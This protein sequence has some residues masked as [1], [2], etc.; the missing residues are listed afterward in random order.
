MTKAI[1]FDADGVTIAP[2][3]YFSQRLQ[4][5]V[6]IPLEKVLPFFKNELRLCKTGKADLKVEI[7]KYLP[8]WGWNDTLDNLLDT[9]FSGEH[10]TDAEILKIVDELRSKGV[11][12]H[13][14]SDNE[15]YRVAYVTNEM[16]LGKR[17]DGVFFSCNLGYTKSDPEFYQKVIEELK[18]QPGEIMY[19]DD[20]PKNVEVAKS[21]GINA[22]VYT[23]I[24]L[25]R[26]GVAELLKLYSF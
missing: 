21:S 8:G 6:G 25:L 18:L 4:D 14:A 24:D 7:S 10:A 5:E 17:F 20:D 12:C 19:W 9:W 2:H 3:P 16:G 23:G 1:L 26:Q 22:N 15:K 11:K 13:L